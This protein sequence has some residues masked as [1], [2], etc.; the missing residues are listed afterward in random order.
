MQKNADIAKSR[1]F[2]VYSVFLHVGFC[3]FNPVFHA[4]KT[5]NVLTLST[6]N[7]HIIW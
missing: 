1:G 7:Y 6:P 5:Y 4:Y 3:P 2:I